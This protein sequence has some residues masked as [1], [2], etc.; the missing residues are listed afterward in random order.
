MN[1]LHLQL[2]QSWGGGGVQMLSL[3]KELSDSESGINN[4]FYCKSGSVLHDKCLENNYP[5]YSV[6]MPLKVSLNAII[7]LIQVLSKERIDIIHMH[8]STALTL[9]AITNFIF[10]TP[11]GI[12]HKK[13]SFAIKKKLFSKY[14]YNHPNLKKIIC[15]SQF[16]KNIASNGIR[17]KDKLV[18]VY[19]GIKIPDSNNTTFDGFDKLN[20]SEDKKVIGHIGNHIKAKDLDTFVDV[21]NY[22][23]NVKKVK[24][25]HF[26][27]IGAYSDFTQSIL[28]RV[29][30][31]NLT[32]FIS[33]IGP[34]PN[35]SNWFSSFDCFLLTSISEGLPLVI[36]EAFYYK[37]P[38]VSTNV[39]GISEIITN[40]KNGFLSEPK[41]FKHLGEQVI[42][43][44]NDT[45]LADEFAELSYNKLIPKFTVSTMAQNILSVYNNVLIRS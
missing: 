42:E 40:N 12:F 25:Y 11:P 6:S 44:T 17:Q 33:L 39:G 24:E 30:S 43:I 36:Y 32:S 20:I 1:I 9:F 4:I 7:K 22:I 14:K 18:V 16:S 10:K 3:H 27:Q 5:F 2:E 41:D 29:S 21:I 31:L 15:V 8:G 26:I 13:T 34:T 37:T 35:A 45:K 38:V 19:D 28:D 23:V